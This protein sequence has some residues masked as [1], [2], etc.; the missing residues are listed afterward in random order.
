MKDEGPLQ[1]V[2]YAVPIESMEHLKQG[3][4]T[5]CKEVRQESIKEALNRNLVRRAE[6]GLQENGLQF[7]H[8]LS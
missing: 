2:V 1:S 3:I 5:A 7:E 8:A 4:K 6:L